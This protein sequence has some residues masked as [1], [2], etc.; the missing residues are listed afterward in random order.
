MTIW[1]LA[2]V[3]LASLAALGYR[4]GAIR[5]VFS[6]AGI[7]VAALLA[8]P[9]GEYFKPLLPRVGIYNP[10]LIWLLGPLEAFVLVLIVF[11]LVGSAVHRRTE[12]HY[13]YRVG[14]LQLA[15]WVRLNRRL[16][17]C[18]GMLNGAAY[19][20]LV[21]FVLFNFSYWTVQI[22]SS[23]AQT[24]TTRLINRL[25]RDLESTGMARAARAVAKL[26]ENYYATADLFGLLCQNPQL[27]N[28]LTRYPAFLSLLER[29]DLKQLA[30][31]STFTGAIQGSMPVG[32]LLHDDQLTAILHNISLTDIIWES[33]QTNMDDLMAYLK[34][35]QS[36]KYGSEKILGHWDFNIATTTSYLFLGRPNLLPADRAAAHERARTWLT[37]YVQTTLIVAPDRQVFLHNLPHL[38]SP[39]GGETAALH[40]WPIIAHTLRSESLPDTESS[41]LTGHWE[42]INGDCQL[43]FTNNGI[44]DFLKVQI[45]DDR[46]SLTTSEGDTLV[47]DREE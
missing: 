26:P 27:G 35:G 6:F 20:V 11:K 12:L 2:L 3:M 31:D 30:Q 9:V 45:E 19:F 44:P 34:T 4:Q 10:F 33:V 32:K 18:L 43:K 14:D 15:L 23:D 36:P 29:D 37:N 1:I 42:D 8:V 16:G 22:A 7:I 13:K 46:F 28:R 24:W 38:K 39:P 17:L 25:G 21:A 47:F 40:L 41:T 5:V